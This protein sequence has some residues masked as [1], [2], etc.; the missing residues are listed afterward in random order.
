MWLGE[1]IHQVY[2]FLSSPFLTLSYC[3]FF[4]M[5]IIV[6][7][8]MMAPPLP[9]ELDQKCEISQQKKLISLRSDHFLATCAKVSPM[10]NS[11]SQ[12]FVLLIFIVI[13]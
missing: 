12:T 3:I 8:A 4:I 2:F 1:L 11:Y 10:S 6:F 7:D 13:T 5:S 9:P